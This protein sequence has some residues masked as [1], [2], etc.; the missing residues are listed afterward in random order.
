MT[1]IKKRSISVTYWYKRPLPTAVHN[2][3]AV[4]SLTFS[5]IIVSLLFLHPCYAGSAEKCDPFFKM[6]LPPVYPLH[7]HFL[8]SE[9][10]LSSLAIVISI[11][12]RRRFKCPPRISLTSHGDKCDKIRWTNGRY[13]TDLGPFL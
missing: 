4:A 3:S 7:L 10:V 13:M 5:L 2:I 6:K 8:H 11:S 1:I 12:F 9:F